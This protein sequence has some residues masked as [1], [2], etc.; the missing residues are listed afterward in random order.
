MPREERDDDWIGGD[1][2]SLLLSMLVSSS[3]TESTSTSR[4]MSGGTRKSVSCFRLQIVVFASTT[5]W[6]DDTYIRMC[7]DVKV[8]IWL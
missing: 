3:G 4:S 1:E 8:Y 5:E 6:L 2:Y 7:V